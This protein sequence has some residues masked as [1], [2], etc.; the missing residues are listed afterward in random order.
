MATT[1]PVAPVLH[2]ARNGNL[3]AF[4]VNGFALASWLARVPDVKEALDLT[5][6]L[7]AILLLGISSGALIG[8]PLAGR[9]THRLGAAR[10]VRL[11]MMVEVPG[12][13]VAAAAIQ[14]KAPLWMA[15][16]PLVLVG[17]GSGVWDVAM[18][19]EGTVIEQGLGRAIMPWFHAAF[20]GGTVLGALIGAV[21][22][23]LKVP[24]LLHLGVVAVLVAVAA[25][26]G[27]SDFLPAFDEQSDDS[28]PAPVVNH[29]SAWTEPRT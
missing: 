6:G 29:R 14:L 16:V 28:S 7:L 17:L 27:T 2:R 18:N 1:T 21:I 20:S 3:M 8:L 4:A 10:T 19:L 26:W 9:L 13:I 25:W 11:G 23:F 24:L 22:V 12:L 5:P 15:A